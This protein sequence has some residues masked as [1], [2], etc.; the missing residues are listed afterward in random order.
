MFKDIKLEQI[1]NAINNNSKSFYESG[2]EAHEF[3]ESRL[4]FSVES[5]DIIQ[6]IAYKNEL[7]L[8]T[9]QSIFDVIAIESGN[10]GYSSI[11]NIFEICKAIK[12]E[13]EA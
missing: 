12:Y 2:L 7:K 3:A 10:I 4:G 9:V 1:Y 11:A 13:L 6:A 8:E 5:D